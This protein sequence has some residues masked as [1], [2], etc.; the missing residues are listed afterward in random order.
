MILLLL[1]EFSMDDNEQYEC[2]MLLQEIT[3]IVFSPLLCIEQIQYLEFLIP[4]YL[5][6]FRD[7]LQPRLLTPKCHY[8]IHLF[9]LI[10]R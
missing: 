9:R 5:G 4:Q 1:Y 10:T 8:L 2:V 6:R 7:I 3:A